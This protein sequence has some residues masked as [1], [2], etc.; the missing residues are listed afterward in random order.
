MWGGFRSTWIVQT[1]M[2]SN[3]PPLVWMSTGTLMS[4]INFCEDR[5]QIDHTPGWVLITI[6]LS[7][8]LNL[9]SLGQRKR[10][11]SDSGT[12]TDT[13]KRSTGW[14]RRWEELNQ[15]MVRE[16]NNNSQPRILCIWKGLRAITNYFPAQ[17]Q[18]Y[19]IIPLFNWQGDF[20]SPVPT[21]LKG[22]NQDKWT[23]F[24][25]VLEDISPLYSQSNIIQKWLVGRF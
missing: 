21:F 15:H 19:A 14:R 10:P 22:L 25:I 1:G 20:H 16:C 23:S 2:F 3:L 13:R 9:D 6:N 18:P 24:S 12:K 8:Q 11:H 17:N 7:W 4:L 5:S